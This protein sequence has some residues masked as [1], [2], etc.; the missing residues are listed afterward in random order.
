ME[1]DNLSMLNL[2]NE[3]MDIGKRRMARH[4]SSRSNKKIKLVFQKLG[5][6]LL[7]KES[8]FTF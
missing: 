3:K 2:K 6:S 8:I 5:Q 7:A 1:D 4:M